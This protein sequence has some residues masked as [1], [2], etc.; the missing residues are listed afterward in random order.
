[1]GDKIELEICC[2]ACKG[3]GLYVGFAEKDGCAVVCYKCEGTGKVVVIHEIFQERKRRTDV[4]RVFSCSCG[5]V[6]A[7]DDVMGERNGEPFLYE[8]SKYGCTYDEW[9]EGVEPMPMEQLYC[10][11]IWD[12]RGVGN[13]PLPRCREGRKSF[14]GRISDCKFFKDRAE[15]WKLYWGEISGGHLALNNEQPE[16]RD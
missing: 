2:P 7:P 14:Y 8:F 3:T 15:C 10:P 11:Y 6:H 4:K 1:M 16:R 12:N 9:L 13:E 5:Y